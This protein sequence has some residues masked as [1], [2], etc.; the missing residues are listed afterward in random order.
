MFQSEKL[1]VFEKLAENHRFIRLSPK[2]FFQVELAEFANAF[3]FRLAA[4]KIMFILS[5]SVT[6]AA[7]LVQ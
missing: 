1:S 5:F 2:V 7:S 6:N 3:A 4:T